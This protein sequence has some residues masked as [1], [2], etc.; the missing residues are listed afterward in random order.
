M[1]IIFIYKNDGESVINAVIIIYIYTINNVVIQGEKNLRLKS[2]MQKSSYNIM[3]SS[4]DQKKRSV[5]LQKKE[6]ASD[7]RIGKC[8]TWNRMLFRILAG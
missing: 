1:K 4:F 7:R 3:L 8:H 5:E 2:A 6:K